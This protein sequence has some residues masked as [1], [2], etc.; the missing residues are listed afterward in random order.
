MKSA[1]IRSLH[2]DWRSAYRTVSIC[3]GFQEDKHMSTFAFARYALSI[4]VAAS[5]VT[6]ELLLHL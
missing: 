5:G 6:P 1:Q 2:L 4:S 3:S